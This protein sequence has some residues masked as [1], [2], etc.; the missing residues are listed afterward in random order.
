MLHELGVTDRNLLQRGA[1]LD[2]SARQLIADATHTVDDPPAGRREPQLGECADTVEVLN[3]V[4]RTHHVP[5]AI[6]AHPSG[7]AKENELQAEP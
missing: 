6:A 3:D 4:L 1:E 7:P 5:L 2:R